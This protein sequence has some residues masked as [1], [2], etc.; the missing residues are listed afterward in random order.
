[1]AACDICSN[2]IA[3][4]V[5]RTRDVAQNQRVEL[6]NWEDFTKRT[7]SCPS[8]S[9]IVQYLVSQEGGVL[10]VQPFAPQCLLYIS[11]R[12]SH[13]VIGA[14]GVFLCPMHEFYVVGRVR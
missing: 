6:G 11:F 2:I 5:Q 7:G 8:C 10:R 3:P 4:M 13:V 14:V 9:W 12:Y 1:M